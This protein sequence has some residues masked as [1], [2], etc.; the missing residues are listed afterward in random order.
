MTIV[1]DKV[2]YRGYN[3]KQAKWT[4]GLQKVLTWFLDAD[5]NPD[6]HQN[7]IITF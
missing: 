2:N 3:L 5:D 4:E 1:S 6:T 7:V